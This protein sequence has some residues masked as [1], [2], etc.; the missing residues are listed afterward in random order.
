MVLITICVT[1]FDKLQ[2]QVFAKDLQK[3]LFLDVVEMSNE[4]ENVI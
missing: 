3:L 1:T 2:S 4:N